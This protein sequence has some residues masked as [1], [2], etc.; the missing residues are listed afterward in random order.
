VSLWSDDWDYICRG[1]DR[2]LIVEDVIAA[3]RDPD[4]IVFDALPARLRY[5]KEGVGPPTWL[6]VVV[7]FEREGGRVYNAIPMRRIPRRDQ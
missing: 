3:I 7:L 1:Q 5:Y 4:R 2:R 6:R